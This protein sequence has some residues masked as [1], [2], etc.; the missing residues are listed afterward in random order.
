H[1]R[2]HGLG[3]GRDV[4]AGARDHDADGVE[5]MPPR[6]VAHLIGKRGVTEFANEFDDGRGRAGGGME[7][8]QGFG[9]DHGLHLGDAATARGRLE[10]YAL[11]ASFTSASTAT[12]PSP[13]ARTLSGIVCRRGTLDSRAMPEGGTRA[14]ASASG[15]PAG[16]PR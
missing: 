2:E 7:R 6:V 16:L 4:A 15:P 9:V 5:Q 1:R 12:T 3:A 14:S 13:A 8:L 10:A 11:P